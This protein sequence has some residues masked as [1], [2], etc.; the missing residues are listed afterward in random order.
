MNVKLGWLGLWVAAVFLVGCSRS[1]QTPEAVRRG[2][3]EYL[4]S[5]SDLD[6]GAIQVDVTSVNFRQ[7]EADATV[8]FRPKGG[9][10]GSGMEMRY[11]LELKGGRWAVKG[12][13]QSLPGIVPHGAP[14]PE[15]GAQAPQSRMP[16]D[17]PPLGR[18]KPAGPAK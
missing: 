17:H 8:A 11:T 3:M 18:A 15:E 16:S 6:L 2:I 7:N 5:R 14:A 12:K 10:P 1:S 13:G 4:A 9:A